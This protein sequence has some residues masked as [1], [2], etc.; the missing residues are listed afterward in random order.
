MIGAGVSLL[1]VLGAVGSGRAILSRWIAGERWT[2]ALDPAA[3]LGV[4]GLLGLGAFG[5]VT[6][7]IGLLPGGFRWGLFPM[8]LGGLAGL[9][10]FVRQCGREPIRLARPAG[11]LLLFPVL[12]ILLLS[13]AFVGALTPSTPADWDS[14]AYHLAVPKWWI[15]AG[16]I[17]YIP[18]IHH[19]NFPFVVDN[20]FVWGE[21]WGGESGAKTFVAAIY[22]LGMLAV[23]G[24][25]RARYGVVAGF[26]AALA[27]AGVPAVLW[28]SG[29]A[30]IDVANGLYGGLGLWFVARYLETSNRG[31]LVLASVLLGLAVASKYTG[32]QTLFVAA[33]G[34]GVFLLTLRDSRRALR[35]SGFLTLV[36]LAIASPW[37]GRNVLNTGNPVYPFFYEKLGGRG[38]SQF[39]ADVYREEQHTFGVGR[40]DGK[41]NPSQFAHAALGL[42]YQPGRYA[43]PQ[44]KAGRGLPTEAIGPVAILA[45]LLWAF[46]GRARRAENYIL[47]SVFALLLMWFVLSQQSRYVLGFLPPLALLAGGAAVS[48]RAGP[49]LMGVIALQALYSGWLL[50]FAMLRD[51]LPVLLGR[52]SPEEYRDRRIP[53]AAPARA[54]DRFGPGTK[55]ALYDEVF[56]YCLNVPYFWA[57]PGHSS[58][59]PYADLSSGD[60][61]S[62][63]MLKLGFTH[64][65]VNLTYSDE[66]FREA[67]GLLG[68]LRPYTETEKTALNA[69]LRTAWRVLLAESVETGD[70][71]LVERFREGAP[72]ESTLWM[73]VRP[74]FED[75]P[76]P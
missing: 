57:N 14:L 67:I 70:L 11:L 74:F 54:I 34:L 36:A 47:T 73:F 20:L 31:E 17:T 49:L 22:G 41:L 3:R 15:E 2:A 65:Y 30:Y 38:W 21:R 72:S 7:W 23:F 64:V 46:S 68:P 24:L 61:W 13:I 51:R 53:F 69:D 32:L 40:K 33:L 45:L 18:F 52:I 66:R 71:Q 59:I 39:Q 35:A 29:T 1:F 44:P 10:L 16:R 55:V 6:F 62:K 9:A 19:S 5:W 63:A 42:A 48:L 75:P 58:L 27:F 4:S 12:L 56:G 28:E 76:A 37:Y 50:N 25:G 43:N 60:A 26:W 8:L